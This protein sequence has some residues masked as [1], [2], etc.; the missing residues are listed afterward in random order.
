M[1]VCVHACVRACMR[2]FITI[3]TATWGRFGE[4]GHPANFKVYIHPS[5]PWTL[6]RMATFFYNHHFHACLA[7]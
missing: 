3:C 6:D 7:A 5:V 2:V 4:T 1:F